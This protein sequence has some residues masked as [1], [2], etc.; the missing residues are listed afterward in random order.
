MAIVLNSTGGT[1]S[2]LYILGGRVL[3]GVVAQPALAGHEDHCCGH[4]HSHDGRIMIRLRHNVHGPQAFCLSSCPDGCQH[5]LKNGVSASVCVR[6]ECGACLSLQDEQPIVSSDLLAN[7]PALMTASAC[8]IR[9]E[10]AARE[11]KQRGWI[12]RK[13][14]SSCASAAL[15]AH[16]LAGYEM[17]SI[18]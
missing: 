9:L 8:S 1:K 11:R 14:H 4:M 7:C 10:S 3:L 15:Y 6:G 2:H 17:C 12:T 5:L 13:H 18:N 16:F